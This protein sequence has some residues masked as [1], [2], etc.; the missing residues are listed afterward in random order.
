MKLLFLNIYGFIDKLIK[1]VVCIIAIGLFIFVPFMIHRFEIAFTESRILSHQ[2][3]LKH[4][5]NAIIASFLMLDM[6]GDLDIDEQEFKSL[7]SSMTD[8]VDKGKLFESFD[9]DDNDG[10]DVNEFVSHLLK[11]TF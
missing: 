7:L 6:N 2:K 11:Q 8:D 5:T 9:E 3:H 10:I 1:L 4:K